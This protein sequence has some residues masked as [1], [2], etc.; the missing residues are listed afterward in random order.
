MA[1]VESGFVWD[2]FPVNLKS[3]FVIQSVEL[4]AFKMIVI[5]LLTLIFPQ[6]HKKIS[7]LCGFCY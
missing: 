3:E 4:T 5:I 7:L 6:Y 1:E 2:C